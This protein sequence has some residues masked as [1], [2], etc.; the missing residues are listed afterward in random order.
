MRPGSSRRVSTHQGSRQSANPVSNSS[1][2]RRTCFFDD[3]GC[4]SVGEISATTGCGGPAVGGGAG[5]GRG[6]VLGGSAEGTTRAGR[7]G[8]AL[9]DCPRTSCEIG[10]V[11]EKGLY[12]ISNRTDSAPSPNKTS[13]NRDTVNFICYSCKLYFLSFACALASVRACF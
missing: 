3:N 6:I 2:C 8:H 12:K 7:G 9:M 4:S 13:P 1:S 5:V 10:C 11:S